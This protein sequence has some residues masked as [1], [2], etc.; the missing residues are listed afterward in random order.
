MVLPVTVVIVGLLTILVFSHPIV[1]SRLQVRG[2]VPGLDASGFQD[3]VD[4]AA[5][6]CAVS[7]LFADAEISVT[8]APEAADGHCGATASRSV[9]RLSLVIARAP[10]QHRAR[11]RMLPLL[12]H[13]CHLRLD[14]T[15]RILPAPHLQD[16]SSLQYASSIPILGPQACK[17]PAGSLREHLTRVRTQTLEHGGGSGVHDDLVWA[18]LPETGDPALTEWLEGASCGPRVK[19]LAVRAAD[20]AGRGISAARW[21]QDLLSEH[22]DASALVAEAEECMRGAGLWP[23]PGT[24]RPEAGT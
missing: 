20:A 4:E 22:P 21:R 10:C 18:G 1:W 24:D 2:R 12:A 19:A 15:G 14:A 8:A 7:R 5:A 3:A 6:L 9:N 17:E 23:W 16:P 11:V 13:P